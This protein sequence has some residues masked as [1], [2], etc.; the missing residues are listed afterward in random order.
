MNL[1]YSSQLP[2]QQPVPSR[3]QAAQRLTA[4]PMHGYGSAYA[5]NMRAL[6][7][8]NLADYN[9]AADQANFGYAAEHMKGQQGLALQGLRNMADEQERATQ[10]GTARLQNMVGALRGLM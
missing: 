7:S 2:Y 4:P 1:Q 5:D 9:R 3:S 6:G 8:A 10:L